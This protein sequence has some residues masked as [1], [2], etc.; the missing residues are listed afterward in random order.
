MKHGQLY[1]LHYSEEI[2][3]FQRKSKGKCFENLLKLWR[4]F[5]S[6]KRHG[7]KGPVIVLAVCGEFDKARWR[8][9]TLSLVR[10]ERPYMVHT[11][12]WMEN[13]YVV[14]ALRLLFKNQLR[15]GDI[16]WAI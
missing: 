1:N 13:S 14:H 10:A 7:H 6:T 8:I 11:F 2:V 16:A 4:K 3:E 12:K 15:S 9:A 5:I